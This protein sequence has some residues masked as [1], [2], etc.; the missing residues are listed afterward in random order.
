[1]TGWDRKKITIPFGLTIVGSLL[2]VFA[3]LWRTEIGHNLASP[4]KQMNLDINLYSVDNFFDQ[5][6]NKYAGEIVSKSNLTYRTDRLRNKDAVIHGL[7]D[8]R[9]FS[10][11]RIISIERDYVVNIENGKTIE[12]GT[13]NVGYMMAPGDRNKANFFLRHF[14][15]T[16]LVE[17]RFEKEEIIEGLTT[18]K[19]VGKSVD[20]LTEGFTFLPEVPERYKVE[21]SFDISWWVEP[22]TGLLIKFEES[23]QNNFLDVKTSQLVYPRN[24]YTNKIT[25]ESIF[26]LVQLAKVRRINTI[27]TTIV[28]PIM[29]ALLGLTVL[30]GTA[31][32][33]GFLGSFSGEDR[34]L[35]IMVKIITYLVPALTIAVSLLFAW[36]LKA[37][38]EDQKFAEFVQETSQVERSVSR[39]FDTY[40]SALYGGRGLF[41]A[42]IEVDKNEWKDYTSAL[43]VKSNFP[44]L[45]FMSHNVWVNATDEAKFVE[46]MNDD[47]YDNYEIFPKTRGVEGAR[48]LTRFLEPL[49]DDVKS[50]IGFDLLTEENR[51]AALLTARD[52]GLPT[53][54]KKVVLLVDQEAGNKEPGVIVFL[55]VYKKSV[56]I[57]SIDQ[58]RDAHIGYVGGAVRI[59]DLLTDILGERH[60]VSFDIYDTTEVKEENIMYSWDGS[61]NDGGEMYIHKEVVYILDKPWTVVFKAPLSS[62]QADNKILALIVS[63]GVGGAMLIYLTLTLLVN[64]NTRAKEMATELT[65][66]LEGANKKLSLTLSGT[67]VGTWSVNEETKKIELGSHSSKMLGVENVT[68]MS[69]EDVVSLFDEGEIDKLRLL[70]SGSKEI[71]DATVR[72]IKNGNGERWVMFRGRPASE[73]DKG[74]TTLEVG[75]VTDVTNER[76]A[77][78]KLEKKSA[79]LEKINDLM[80]G[81]ELKMK[82]LKD[83]LKQMGVK[84]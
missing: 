5:P 49:T 10:G 31:F 3:F 20:D 18:Y 30:L 8:V 21:N 70:L 74:D 46:K 43:L 38:N 29:M 67:G 77:L 1:M 33:R 7:F 39:R 72:L 58:R 36:T 28:T 11:A 60:S 47:G 45:T 37:W 63:A 82:E 23:G 62:L 25:D 22:Y 83:K 26:S 16:S 42:S 79:E 84:E 32:W 61:A 44:G 54:T 57:T 2:L 52:T 59:K 13:G 50:K 48:V 65:K 76:L 19:F 75:I 71:T 24:K 81:R 73:S 9:S 34:R 27:V 6:S 64:A 12:Q 69:I 15:G 78:Q 14:S 4:Y 56:D 17:M 35:G 53:T 80:V 68:A 41:L 66:D 51:R 55:P 40:L